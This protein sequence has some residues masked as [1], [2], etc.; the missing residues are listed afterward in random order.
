MSNSPF[1]VDT[2]QQ[3]LMPLHPAQAKKL[4]NS[5]KAAV[6]RRFPFT[7][8]L[9][10]EILEPLVYPLTLKID[11]GSKVTGFALVTEFA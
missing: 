10:R 9:K 1:L 3:P 2:K 11:P 4:L 5:G 7:L 8:I 6:F